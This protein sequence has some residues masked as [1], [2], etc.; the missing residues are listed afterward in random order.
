MKLEF[1]SQFVFEKYWNIKFVKIRPVGAGLFHVDGR[2]DRHDESNSRVLQFWEMR[3]K[4]FSLWYQVMLK[5][6][7]L[8][9]IK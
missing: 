7:L 5:Y 3:L 9:I 1:S 4:Y 2:K 8:I 6:V